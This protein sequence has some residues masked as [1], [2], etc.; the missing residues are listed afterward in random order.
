VKLETQSSDRHA[1]TTPLVLTSPRVGFRPTSPLNA[2]GTRPEPAVSVPNAKLAWPR[3]TATAEPELDPPEMYRA[4]KAEEHAPY[5]VR[6][7][8][9]PVANW[10]RL[11]FPITIAPSAI[12]RSTAWAWRCGKYENSGQPAV[13]G[14]PATSMLSF[15]ANGTP[16]SAPPGASRSAASNASKA[17]SNG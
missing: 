17:R 9:S 12:R 11:V 4:S 7:P 15:T 6:V 5:G 16:K 2:A 1:G 3:A 13:V 14:R 8:T 10:S